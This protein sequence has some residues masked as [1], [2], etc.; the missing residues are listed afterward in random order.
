MDNCILH[1]WI[2]FHKLI[3]WSYLLTITFYVFYWLRCNIVV[4]KKFCQTFGINGLYL[5]PIKFLS[6]WSM[7]PSSILLWKIS[8]FSSGNSSISF[9]F[10]NILYL[11]LRF[12]YWKK[13]FFGNIF[14]N[15]G[16]CLNNNTASETKQNI[17]ACY[18]DS[19]VSSSA[20]KQ[21]TYLSNK[22]IVIKNLLYVNF[23]LPCPQ[24]LF[25]KLILNMHLT[26]TLNQFEAHNHL[27][28]TKHHSIGSLWDSVLLGY[29]RYFGSSHNY[30]SLGSE[31]YFS[32]GLSYYIAW[33]FRKFYPSHSK[34]CFSRSL[35]SYI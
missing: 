18:R 29:L 8:V 32:L 9:L 25:K 14:P 4:R 15:Q 12:C 34:Y 27:K 7:Y 22:F 24:I 21:S 17:T 31:Y 3:S 28:L 16:V 2:R 13:I 6:V 5:L 11:L 10:W 1:S 35:V 19:D 33:N 20:P 23:C 30:L 26:G